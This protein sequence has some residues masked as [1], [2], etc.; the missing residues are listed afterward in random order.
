M[1]LWFMR[2]RTFLRMVLALLSMVGPLLGLGVAY[3]ML[4]DWTQVP[5]GDV[6]YVE[7]D[8]IGD[9][10]WWGLLSLGTLLAAGRVLFIRDARL[11][12]L[13]LPIAMSFVMILVPN[14]RWQHHPA[15]PSID[16][17]NRAQRVSPSVRAQLSSLHADLTMAVERGETPP[18]ASGP[19]SIV[20]P[21]FRAGVRLTYQYVCLTTDLPFDALLTSSAPG[22]IYVLTR[23]SDPTMRLRATV[24]HRNVDTTTGWLWSPAGT[25]PM[26]LT[27][28]PHSAPRSSPPVQK[29]AAPMSS[30]PAPNAWLPASLPH[31]NH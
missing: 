11:R 29:S 2:L 10:T 18:C 22:T 19:T 30:K 24:L 12:W 6:Y 8:Y 14:Q 20:S 31:A 21:Y 13:W 25:G 5:Q 3:I 7:H 9:A 23:P 27:I 28:S 16:G 26:E 17:P 1:A 4:R 15:F